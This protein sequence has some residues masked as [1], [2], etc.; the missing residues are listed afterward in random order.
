MIATFNFHEAFTQEDPPNK[1][2]IYLSS[3]MD[4]KNFTKLIIRSNSCAN[5]QMAQELSTIPV[6]KKKT[7]VSCSNDLCTKSRPTEFQYPAAAQS[8]QTA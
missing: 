8:F 4:Y 7:A 3:G 5:G 2:G 6:K 1:M